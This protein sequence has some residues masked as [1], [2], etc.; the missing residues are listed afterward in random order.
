M[1]LGAAAL[2]IVFTIMNI[3]YAIASGRHGHGHHYNKH[4][5]NH[6]H[7]YKNR[8]HG[9]HY[10]KHYRG[11][12]HHYNKHRGHGHYSYGPR[13]YYGHYDNHGNYVAYALGGLVVGGILGATLSNSY[14]NGTQYSNYR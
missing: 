11:R 6:G 12:G 14:H 1:K 3:N 9:Q 2:I 7:Q 13:R 10:K 8:G 4:Y 5:G